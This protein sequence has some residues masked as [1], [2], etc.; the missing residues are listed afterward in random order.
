MSE[1]I[2]IGVDIGGTQL[3]AATVDADGHIL[4][5]RRH[6]T[7]AGDASELVTVLRSVAS[8]L[9][10]AGQLPIGVGIAGLVT[11]E[12]VVRYGPNI[13]VRDLP[14]A[15]AL[16]GMS[17]GGVVVVNDASAA[18]FGEQRFGA[19]RGASDLLLF[20]VGTGVGG[21][22]V[23]AGQLVLG[24]GGFAGELGHLIVAEGGRPCPC[25]N[26]GCIEAYASGSAIGA[27]ARE[28]LADPAVDSSLREVE[29][30]VGKDVTAAAE[31]GDRLASRV[32]EDAGRWLGVAA[33][34]LVNVLDPQLVLVG[35]GAATATAPWLLPAA[36][37]S[38]ADHLVGAD[39]REPPPIELATLGDDAGVVGS[40]LLAAERAP[41]AGTV[42][43]GEH[44]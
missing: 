36:R 17:A 23:V 10:A 32:L 37:D 3:R 11:A 1:P 44:P 2:A 18:T 21:G 7:P 15:A 26:L 6:P 33:A 27:M 22:V 40:A 12:G 42:P 34:S 13:G 28:A 35:G 16:A 4:D 39:W 38:L 30:P 14:L 9:D 41:G 8:D 5:R 31:A 19:G 29:D 24:R 43:A 20:T 25:G